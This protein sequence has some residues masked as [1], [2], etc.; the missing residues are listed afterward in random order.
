MEKLF[1]EDNKFINSKKM[2]SH[3]RKQ[4]EKLYLNKKV[5]RFSEKN[6]NIMNL[7]K[8]TSFD[9][10]TIKF[11]CNNFKRKSFMDNLD[12]YRCEQNY[13]NRL[14]EIKLDNRIDKLEEIIT[15]AM[16]KKQTKQPNKIQN[17]HF[18]FLHANE[19]LKYPKKVERY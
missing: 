6:W 3:L 2:W 7:N 12:E 19:E 4:K 18:L 15:Y 8:G 16:K 17:I 1:I 5:F 14:R 11:L 13:L 10:E 9:L